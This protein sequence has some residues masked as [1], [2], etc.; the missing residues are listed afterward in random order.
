MEIREKDI[1]ISPVKQN[2]G[3]SIT[4]PLR[5]E[6]GRYIITNGILVL[7]YTTSDL[8]VFTRHIKP[9]SIILNESGKKNYSMIRGTR[10]AGGEVTTQ[11]NITEIRYLRYLDDIYN[12]KLIDFQESEI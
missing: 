1:T 11:G 3:A 4:V 8:G 2:Y 10:K 5:K 6:E 9:V 7:F 12:I